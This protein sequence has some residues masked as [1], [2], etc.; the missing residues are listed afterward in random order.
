MFQNGPAPGILSCCGTL[1]GEGNSILMVGMTSREVLLYSL[2][3]FEVKG[4]LPEVGLKGTKW[5]R[6]R[7]RGF[8]YANSSVRWIGI[9]IL[10]TWWV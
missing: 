4:S 9:G 5:S 6:E 10:S 1:D 7:K 8:A 2:P 3:E